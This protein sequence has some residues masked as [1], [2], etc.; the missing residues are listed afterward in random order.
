MNFDLTSEQSML[1]DQIKLFA[2]EQL[3]PKVQ[4]RDDHGSFFEE[5]L[6]SLSE[7]G[8]LG[9]CVPEA[10][11]GVESDPLALCRAL[12]GL[13]SSDA[14]MALLAALINGLTVEYI[15]ASATEDQKQNWLPQLVTGECWPAW[16]GTSPTLQN[17]AST[18]QATRDGENWILQGTQKFVYMGQHATHFV[19]FADHARGEQAFWIERETEGLQI[20]PV[21]R[22]LG[23]RSTGLSQ[24]TLEGL[25]V[26]EDNRIGKSTASSTAPAWR[27]GNTVLAAISLGIAQGALDR[28]IDYAKQRKQ[29]GKPLAAFQAIQWKIADMAMELE[30]G[31]LLLDRAAFDWQ[32]Q[33]EEALELSSRSARLFTA[34]LAT[35]CAQEAIQIHGGYG[36]TTE[37]EVER[38]YRDA[39]ALRASFG[40]SDLQRHHLARDRAQR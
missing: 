11:D 10:Y 38:Y 37:F 21:Q 34:E 31:R 1:V 13:A 2:K 7:L 27:R 24:L 8:M 39:Q 36:F 19:V 33:D 6:R 28:A 29:F 30:A 23:F 3:A 14:S 12:S 5:G 16:A 15:L 18:I 4:H 26:S 20:A 40:G 9:F 25:V 17:S 22:A 35:K 32:Q